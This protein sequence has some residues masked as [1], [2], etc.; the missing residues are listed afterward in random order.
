MAAASCRARTDGSVGHAA[1]M[2]HSGRRTTQTDAPVLAPP[3]IFEQDEP[4]D[5]IAG[6]GGRPERNRIGVRALLALVLLHQAVHMP[7]R[8]QDQH[9]AADRRRAHDDVFHLVLRNLLKRPPSLDDIY[10]AI[11]VR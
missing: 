1:P 7:Q 6:P 8:P 9:L 3:D 2:N 4:C 10:L 11:L 5:D